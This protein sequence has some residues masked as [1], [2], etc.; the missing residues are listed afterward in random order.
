VARAAFDA[1]LEYSKTRVQFN[2]P[3]GLFQGTGFKLADMALDIDMARLLTYR[4]AWLYDQGRDSLKE[5]SMAKLFTSEMAV[6][7]TGQ[8]LQIHGA[9]G[10]MMESPVQRYFRDAK[11]LTISEGPSE[12]QHIIIAQELGLKADDNVNW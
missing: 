10:Y 3:I 4:A 6:R 11:M 8:A 2:K 5:A 7:V 1:A 12:I 9:L